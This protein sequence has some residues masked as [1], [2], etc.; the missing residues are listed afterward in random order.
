MLI[1]SIRSMSTREWIFLGLTTIV[2]VL[3]G[4]SMHM[5][6]TP[7][8]G[9]FIFGDEFSYFR[10]AYDIFSGADLSS[11]LQYGALYPVVA[12]FFF[13]L[14]DMESIYRALRIFNIAIF[15]SSAIPMFLLARQL[16]PKS[17]MSVLLPIFVVTIPFSSFVHLIW[18]EPIY[19][20]LFLWAAV[21]LLQFYRQ[22]GTVIGGVCGILLALLFHT[23]PGAGLVVQLAAFI[24]IVTLVLTVP[25]LER[26]LLLAPIVSLVVCCLGLTLP[27]MARN[28]SLGVGIIGYAGATSDLASRIAEFGYGQ[29]LKEAILGAFYQLSYVFIGT[30]GLLGVLAVLTVMRWR[31]LPRELLILIVFTLTSTAGVIA[32]STIGATGYRVLQYWMPIGRYHSVIFPLTVSLAICL[33]VRAQVG[34]IPEIFWQ[35]LVT[36]ILIAI[37]IIATPLLFATPLGIVTNPEM[38]LPLWFID[39]GRLEWRG[40]LDPS[41]MQRS[42]L[43][44]VAGL[45]GLVLMLASKN[46]K[47]LYG[48]VVLV[49]VCSVAVTLAQQ[50]YVRIMGNTQAGLNDA[51]RFLYRQGALGASV[52]FDHKLGGNVEFISK[53]WAVNRSADAKKTRYRDSSNVVKGEDGLVAPE[54]FVSPE[55]LEF[56]IIFNANGIFVYRVSTT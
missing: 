53:F 49:L 12:S 51:V 39:D 22:P 41:L 38:G 28:L 16:F 8:P 17:V 44:I 34:S 33:L 14:G 55:K 20:T 35:V 32:L 24:S 30:W 19:F 29:I 27:W 4:Y 1:A 52:A 10:F 50:R 21:A 7:I 15:V 2:A 31:S 18:A 40:K 11:H 9:P 23:K 26:K 43:A 56:P 48:C 47:L 36:M 13:N 46:K 42:T 54:Y 6:G 25:K 37:S 3:S 5:V 45:A